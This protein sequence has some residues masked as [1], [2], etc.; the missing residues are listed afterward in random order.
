MENIKIFQMFVPFGSK[1]GIW[2]KSVTYSIDLL[3][4][5]FRGESWAKQ[6]K[7]QTPK[8]IHNPNQLWSLWTKTMPYFHVIFLPLSHNLFLCLHFSM[9]GFIQ[10][11]MDWFQIK[12]LKSVRIQGCFATQSICLTNIGLDKYLIS[13]LVTFS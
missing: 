3:A 9:H 5:T 8:F 6:R 13:T 11:R 10:T 1:R 4:Q 12:L 2:Y 7:V